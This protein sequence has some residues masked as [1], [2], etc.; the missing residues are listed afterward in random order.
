MSV[1]KTA[2]LHPQA[3]IYNSSC[4]FDDFYTFTTGD[5]WTTVAG[6]SGTC[7]ATLPDK[8]VATTAATDNDLQGIRSTLAGS[9]YTS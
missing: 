4:L 2:N 9:T 7:V 5:T 1:L 6:S 8:L 3:T